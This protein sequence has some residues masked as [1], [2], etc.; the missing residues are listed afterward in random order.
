MTGIGREHGVPLLCTLGDVLLGEGRQLLA[1]GGV[2]VASP[3]LSRRFVGWLETSRAAAAVL[4]AVAWA[5]TAWEIHTFDVNIF[6]EFFVGVPVLWQLMQLFAFLFD[7]FWAV[8]P[9]LAYL[10]FIW[11][12][13]SLA[14]RAISGI[15]MLIPSE[16]F[17]TTRLL[18]PAS[19]VAPVHLFVVTAYIGA[20]VGMYGMFYPWRL[21]KGLELVQRTDLGTRILGAVCA[22][23][24]IS[25]IATGASI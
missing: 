2:S 24:G 8:A 6:R 11:M 17:Q 22:V 14:M 3:S 1:F 7:H 19:G 9:V 23:L 16:L 12:P 5:W 10:T 15:L 25:L 18:V 21:E 20:V 4:T 13:K